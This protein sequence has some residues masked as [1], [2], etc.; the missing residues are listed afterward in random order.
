MND[1]LTGT[2]V[3]PQTAGFDFSF[4]FQTE[5]A[6][7]SVAGPDGYFKE[8]NPAFER[9]LGRTRRQLLER[10]LFEF[11]LPADIPSTLKALSELENETG[12]VA[13]ENR[14]VH[15]DGSLRWL[16]WVLKM[17]TEQGLWYA[18]ARDVTE[19]REAEESLREVQERLSLALSVAQA[20]SWD[21]DLLR[22]RMHLD[23]GTELLM[24]LT[25]RQFSGGASRL[26]KL[27]HADD[28]ARLVA[29][30]RACSKD[31]DYIDA[32]FRLFDESKGT[33]H[34]A[35]RGRVVTRD[36]RS[37]PL[38]AVGIAFDLTDQKALEEQ[39]LALVMNDALTGVRNRRSFDQAMRREWRSALR[40]QRSLSVFMIDIDEFKHYNDSF[41][42][43]A[44]DDALCSVAKAL[45]DTVTRASDLLAR[46]GGEEFVVLLPD[47][48]LEEAQMMAGQL[49]ESVRALQLP[50]AGSVHGTVTVS[51]GLASWVPSD[52]VKAA[53]L[54][55]AADKALYRAKKTGRNRFEDRCS[56]D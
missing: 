53:D 49:L 8:V 11:V 4:L 34:I 45:G 15:M 19:F 44:G 55:M 32:D 31:R 24:G 48:G 12:E 40:R 42:H 41:G 37:Q 18:T 3:A 50:H 17:D 7:F 28:R 51:I 14:W 1:N 56:Q 52:S 38:R 10:S 23:T 36:R 2:G 46:Y 43:Q 5:R 16:A 35:V 47:T 22:D 9:L 20:G 13:F 27:M 39:L 25:A 29:V 33:R 21:W 54:L 30:M 6:M 26:L